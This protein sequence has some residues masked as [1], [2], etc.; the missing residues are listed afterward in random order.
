MCF[1]NGSL[2][3]NLSLTCGVPQGTI[4]GPLFLLYINDLPNCL[5]NC[6]PRMYAGDTH[7]TYAGDCVNNLQLYLNQD[8]DNVHNWLRANKLTLNMTKTEFMLI[9]SR[10]RLSTLAD[11]PTIITIND[12]QVSQVTTAKS[13]GVTIDNK[14]D[15]SS[16]IDKLT[17]KVASGIGAIKRI[18]HLVP[19]ATLHLVYQALIQPHFDYCNILFGETAG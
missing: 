12:N 5:S 13:L 3:N 17:K 15:W 9:S 1:S 4:L 11:S 14:L 16:H 18:S 8:L 10:Q 6:E 7:L 19:Q 2:S